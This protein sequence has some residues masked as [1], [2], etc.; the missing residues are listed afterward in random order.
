MWAE[1]P[2]RW[3]ECVCVGVSSFVM[4]KVRGIG[5]HCGFV[6]APPDF[7]YSLKRNC[8]SKSQM[9][10]VFKGIATNKGLNK[11]LKVLKQKHN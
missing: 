7:C 5:F 2:D 11:L 6:N 8:H 10:G 1:S 4:C 3:C 9:Y